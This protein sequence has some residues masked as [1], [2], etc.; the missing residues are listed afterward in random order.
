MSKQISSIYSPFHSVVRE[1][2]TKLTRQQN[3]CEANFLVAMLQLL[4]GTTSFKSSNTCVRF[5]YMWGLFCEFLATIKTFV[6]VAILS[7]VLAVLNI[8][9]YYC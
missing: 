2:D 4:E 3:C 1:S 8:F 6:V 5:C 7:M 9:E